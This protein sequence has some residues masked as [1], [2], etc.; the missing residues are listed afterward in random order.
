MKIRLSDGDIRLRLN[1]LEVA[2]FLEGRS[3]TTSV[4]DG[5]TLTLIPNEGTTPALEND[6]SAHIVR[7]PA[8]EAI[9]PSMVNPRMYESPPGV[10]PHMLVEMDRQR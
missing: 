4:A 1:E 7:V 10:T 9:S 3:I 5:L 8:S 2:T 6:G